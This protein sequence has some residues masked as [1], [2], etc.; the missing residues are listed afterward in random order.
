VLSPQMA[1]FSEMAKLIIM[2][3]VGG[4]GSFAGPLIGAPPVQILTTYLAKYGE[5]DMVIYALLVIV[6]MRSYMGGLVQMAKAGWAHL[7]RSQSA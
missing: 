5:W 2:V 7:R 4:L 1:D 3:V 6:L